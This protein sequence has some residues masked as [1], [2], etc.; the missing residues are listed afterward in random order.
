LGADSPEGAKGAGAGLS[1]GF[2][3]TFPRKSCIAS[4][5]EIGR[6]ISNEPG[7]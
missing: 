6:S 4:L 2:S 3:A 1:I 5:S 7:W